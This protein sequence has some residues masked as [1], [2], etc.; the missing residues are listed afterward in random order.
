VVIVPPKPKDGMRKPVYP[1][2]L[3]AQGIEGFVTVM[4]A[5]GADGKVA[6]VYIVV[7]APQPEFN[8]AAQRAALAQPWEPATKNGVPYGYTVSYKYRFTE[9]D[10]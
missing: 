9:E 8:E 2:Q 10:Q 7:P 5:I 1:E 4:V 6:S 3:Q